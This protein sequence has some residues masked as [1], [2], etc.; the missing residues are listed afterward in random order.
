MILADKD[1]TESTGEC[2]SASFLYSGGF[3]AQ[4]EVDQFNQTRLV[5]GIDDYDFSW[6]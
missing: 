1:T 5:I 2:Y 4:A 6:N 3:H